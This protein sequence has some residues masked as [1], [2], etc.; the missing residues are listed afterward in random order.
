MSSPAVLL[1]DL[2]MDG[3]SPPG[4]PRRVVTSARRLRHFIGCAR[5]LSAIEGL[6]GKV[7]RL[8]T[9]EHV[10]FVNGRWILSFLWDESLDRA[11]SVGLEKV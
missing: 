11:A 3:E 6:C 1:L 5:S 8:E 2:I 7:Y 10:V 9:D 4:L